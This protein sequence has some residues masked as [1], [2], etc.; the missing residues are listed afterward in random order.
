M[1]F[2][3][4]RSGRRSGDL[5]AAALDQKNQPNSEQNAGDDPY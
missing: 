2:L 4:S 1:A 5:F 3:C